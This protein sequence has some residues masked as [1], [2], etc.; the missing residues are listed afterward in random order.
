MTTPRPRSGSTWSALFE[1]GAVNESL[2]WLWMRQ[3]GWPTPS[4]PQLVMAWEIYS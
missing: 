3:V 2:W 1:L 4:S